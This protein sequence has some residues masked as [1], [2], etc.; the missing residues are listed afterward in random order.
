MFI[1]VRSGKGSPGE[2]SRLVYGSLSTLELLPTL[3]NI[4]EIQCLPVP[5]I[6]LV[7]KCQTSDILVEI[8]LA[9][10]LEMHFSELLHAKECTILQWFQQN[11]SFM[12]FNCFKNYLATLYIIINSIF[13]S[14]SAVNL[15]LNP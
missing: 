3:V 1:T 15:I 6:L 7:L 4:R 5:A 8:T 14:S 2:I 9:K 11:F 12:G 10:S 13:F